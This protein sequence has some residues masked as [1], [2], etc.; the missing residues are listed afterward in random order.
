M[1]CYKKEL[2]KLFLAGDDHWN[3]DKDDSIK[4]TQIPLTKRKESPWD[5]NKEQIRIA[6]E[7]NSS[8]N[9]V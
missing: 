6:W 5:E 3:E 1:K 4:S 7:V 2:T 9:N 8:M